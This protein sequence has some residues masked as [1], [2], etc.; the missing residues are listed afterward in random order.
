MQQSVA[1]QTDYETII[2]AKDNAIA[3]L[4]QNITTAGRSD[5]KRLQTEL[6]TVST[7][8]NG[9]I[10]SLGREKERFYTEINSVAVE[11]ISGTDANEYADRYSDYRQ[12]LYTLVNTESTS[13]DATE[14][15]TEAEKS[16]YA[17]LQT[18]IPNV[19]RETK[20]VL[21]PIYDKLE[22]KYGN[23]S[24]I[25]ANAGQNTSK[26]NE[27]DVKSTETNVTT[28]ENTFTS[29]ASSKLQQ[30]VARQTDYETIIEAKDNAIADLE[31]NITTAG[32][33]DKKRLQTEL[34]TVST[35]RNGDIR[36]LGREKERFYTEINSVAVEQI[37]GTDAN[38]YA[39]R[40]SDYRQQLYTLVN[41]ESTSTD[42]TEKLTEAEKSEYA[43]LQ[44]VIPNVDRE[45]KSVLQPIYDKLEAKYG[46]EIV[47]VSTEKGQ[48][49]NVNTTE[50]NITI[51]ENA[52]TS[53]DSYSNFN[54]ADSY[55]KSISRQEQIVRNIDI[56]TRE[57]ESLEQ[58]IEGSKKSEQKRIV[59]EIA[60]EESRKIDEIQRLAVEKSAF[61]SD[62]DKSLKSS[63]ATQT[64]DVKKEY[65]TAY[66]SYSETLGTM[67][68]G[69]A[70]YDTEMANGIYEKSEVQ[71]YKLLQQMRQV[72]SGDVRSAVLSMIEKLESKNPE[73][74]K[75]R[76]ED[77]EESPV[78]ENV[79]SVSGSDT[80][81]PVVV[82]TDVATVISPAETPDSLA[83]APKRKSMS[84]YSADSYGIY[85][86]P[87]INMGL[88]YRIQIVAVNLRYRMHDFKGLSLIFTELI[89]N[90]NIIRYMTGEYYRYASAREDLPTVRGLGFSDAF[91][92]AYY[93]GR[94]ISIAEA[95]RIEA[96]EYSGENEEIPV[97]I[98]HEPPAGYVEPMD[99]VAD[100]TKSSDANV[101]TSENNV[102][103]TAKSGTLLESGTNADG[104]ASQTSE[105]SQSYV[106]A[107]ENRVT[108][109][110]NAVT[111]ANSKET[112]EETIRK[113]VYFAVQ[114]G[115]YKDN[116]QPW[117][118]KGVAPI[119]YERMQ[120][121]YVRHT[122]GKF[123]EYS[124]ARTAQASI[125]RQ[126]ISDAFVI[127]YIDG[128]KVSFT[129]GIEYQKRMQQSRIIAESSN[130][131]SLSKVQTSE[132]REENLSNVEYAP[133]NLTT[134][135]EENNAEG[136][137]Y[138]VQIG[139]FSKSPDPEILSVFSKVAGDKIHV[140]FPREGLQI[141]RIGVFNSYEE[142]Q[143]TLAEARSFGIVDAFIVAFKGDEQISSSEAIRLQNAVRQIESDSGNAVKTATAN[144][145][146]GAGVQG[147]A[148]NVPKPTVPAESLQQSA[149][150]VEYFVQLGAFV[151]TPDARSMAT[152]RA[153]AST[154][155]AR[156]STVHNGKFTNYRVGAFR[157][158]ADVKS[159]VDS[160]RSMG[161]TDA[162]VVA[163]YNGERIPVVEAKEKER[164]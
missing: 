120:N 131:S 86:M 156:L 66:D 73:L 12:Q 151:N 78:T 114:I 74:K 107:S 64:A 35:E 110:E 83:V 119:D 130:D 1:R 53:I 90:T 58:K 49:A 42:A 112:D 71:E 19:D 125:R 105:S 101:T 44:T 129:E 20:S 142:A 32:R 45:T 111:V 60:M 41:T 63:M 67:K 85:D 100:V 91:I 9:D 127:A 152:F 30:S 92:V 10:R 153:I 132:S 34:E 43:L 75:Y 40:Y 84:G 122:F 13:T 8:R 24:E 55:S 145:Q 134:G 16:E 126:G 68:V 163:F 143:N 133:L 46:T 161:V 128:Q 54:V 95:R 109:G 124:Q 82:S 17:L 37:S 26:D 115:V 31:Q 117:Q 148:T 88:Y 87:E 154:S 4:E 65:S 121:G 27:S 160:A 52:G 97:V 79:V 51:T 158:F 76:I 69:L 6:E 102:Q 23:E 70:F 59:D 47:A 29:T 159:A 136:I 21:Q 99:I 98:R 106:A 62:I 14:K 139:A 39:D 147:A 15:L 48:N 56:S 155:G 123:D 57:I 93:N 33:S 140:K 141:Y 116:R 2:E 149:G 137:S 164:K 144:S 81:V 80:N 89:P 138:Y 96:A 50:N 118:M 108:A 11:Q 36:S 38:E 61:Y 104:T 135:T 103:N 7:E 18:V 22:A 77:A 162:F 146:T 25:V 113:G 3:D 28:T 72:A 5:K 150:G 94:R 157:T